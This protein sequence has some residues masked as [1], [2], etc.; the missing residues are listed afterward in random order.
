MFG[1]G[2]AE[3]GG[4]RTA[5][6]AQGDEVLDL[7]R[8]LPW[9]AGDT[10]LSGTDTLGLLR[11]WSAALPAL[12]RLAA[13]PA[14]AQYRVPREQVRWLPPVLFP[15]KLLCAGA[16]YSDHAKEMGSKVQDA[17]TG[18]PY[19]F[20]KT[21]RNTLIGDGDAI[22]LPGS[23]QKIDWEVELAVVIGRRTKYVSEEDALDAVAGYT[24]FNDVSARD[25]TR[26]TDTQ[27][28][29]DWVS[30]KCEDTFGPMGPV[31]VPAR[32]VPAWDRL[33]LRLLVNGV[34][35]QDA[36]A[37][38][39]IHSIPRQIAFLSNIMTLEPGDVIATGTPAGVGAGRG[40]FLKPGDV[41]V[42]E[43]EGIGRLT[44]RCVAE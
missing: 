44:N 13:A 38:L 16:N 28:T 33:R 30:G 31:I 8:A 25:N 3:V 24:V 23:A 42:T 29:F 22:V 20:V 9:E 7:S 36:A 21:T 34:V 12:E 39:M 40:E 15:D 41:V 35:K 6:L 2:M 18:K 5:A 19:F 10:G 14:R 32:F 27:F 11:N 1:V 26:R 43:I 4:R 17:A 37:S